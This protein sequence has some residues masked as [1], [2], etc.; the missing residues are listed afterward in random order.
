MAKAK[1]NK[2]QE[3]KFIFR[4]PF[5]ENIFLPFVSSRPVLVKTQITTH[6]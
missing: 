2:C 4:P 3:N 6:S 1:Q 5:L